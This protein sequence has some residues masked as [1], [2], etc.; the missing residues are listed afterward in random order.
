MRVNTRLGSSKTR[1]AELTSA[2][3]FDDGH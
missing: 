3:R 2:Y 1:E